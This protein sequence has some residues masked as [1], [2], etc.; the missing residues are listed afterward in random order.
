VF[1]VEAVDEFV[2][3]VGDRHQL[4]LHRFAVLHHHNTTQPTQVK[5]LLEHEHSHLQSL[6]PTAI[7]FSS[8]A[9]LPPDAMQTKPKDREWVRLE[10]IHALTAGGRSRTGLRSG[11]CL[12]SVFELFG[13]LSVLHRELLHLRL[14]RCGC[15]LA[16]RL[17]GCGLLRRCGCCLLRRCHRRLQLLD[18]FGLRCQLLREQSSLLLRRSEL[19]RVDTGRRRRGSGGRCGLCSAPRPANRTR[20]KR[21]FELEFV[22]RDKRQYF[23]SSGIS[24]VVMFV[25]R[26]A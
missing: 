20:A 4:S 2:V 5:S 6:A 10:S 18:L 9:L 3:F 1:T 25:A 7:S 24:Q 21:E 15:L 23:R 16:L 14:S 26:L 8:V 19:R 13:E 11:Q 12:L 17:R 22:R